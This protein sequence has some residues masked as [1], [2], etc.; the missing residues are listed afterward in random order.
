MTK[1]A[2]YQSNGSI[3]YGI[4]EGDTVKEISAPPYE[5]YKEVIG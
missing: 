2:R 5:S 4:V 3:S 1:F